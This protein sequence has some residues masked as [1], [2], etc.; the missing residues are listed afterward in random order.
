MAEIDNLAAYYFHQGTNYEAYKYLGV[1]KEAEDNGTYTYVFRVF[2]P[3][4]DSI[5]VNGDFNGWQD[6]DRMMKITDQGIW[7]KRITADH[8]LEGSFYK[9]RIYSRK[10]MFLKS[11]PYALYGQTL[12]Q[13]ASIFH[14]LADFPWNDSECFVHRDKCIT[15]GGSGEFCSC[16][17]NIYEIHLG[18]WRTRNGASTVNGDAY[19]NYREIADQLVPYVKSMGYTHVELMPVA[20]HPF[21]GSWG[22]QI[23]SYYAPTSRFG[24]PEDF[25][26]FVNKLHENGIGVILDWVPAHFPKDSHG[27]VDFDGLPV[28]E[29][30]GDDR[31]EHVGW[32]TRCFDVARNE[33]ECFLISNAL[34]WLGEYH[35]DGLRVDAVASMLYLDYDREPGKWIPNVN[36]DNKNLEAIAFFKKLNS[37][38][39]SYHRDVLMIAEESTAFP[40]ITM[41]VSEGGLGFNFKWNMGWANDTYEY[42]SADPYFRQNM[43]DKLTFSMTYAFSENYIL[44]VSHDEVVHG[45]RSLLDKM[46]G[47][48]EEKFATD[49]AFMAYQMTHPGKKLMFMG[50]EYGQFREWC[51]SE[52]LE[53]F[54]TDFPLHAQLRDYVADL[55]D[56][57][58][59]SP[60]LWERDFSWEGFEWIYPDMKN[61]N[62]IVYRRYSA[63]GDELTCVINF[64]PNTYK[65]FVIPSKNPYYKEIFNSDNTVYG[66]SGLINKSIRKGVKKDGRFLIKADIPPLSAV[67]LKPD[68]RLI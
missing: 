45:K 63:S 56:L 28:Y 38:V 67:I 17:M 61:E 3:N 32:G 42:I 15:G 52:Q 1:H 29:Y 12:S 6:A 65:Q 59:R 49:R 5:Y 14:T 35:I 31:K 41:P 62:M 18:S 51:F 53:W 46:Y 4:A 23:C 9:Y 10:G 58:L 54:M 19:L 44:P 47:S 60:E 68:K 55:N 34:F 36:G 39:F 40:M 37:V 57:Y 66:G 24:T 33:V 13:T 48:Y 27:L 25:K 43:H 26:Y 8:D 16:P 30:Q 22:Y 21:D 64:S 11:D 7:E 2:A 50:C 20:E